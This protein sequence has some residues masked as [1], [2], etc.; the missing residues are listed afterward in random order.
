MVDQEQYR[1]AW[2]E[3]ANPGK[4]LAELIRRPKVIIRQLDVACDIAAAPPGS[5]QE[6]F[7][8]LS[9][10]EAEKVLKQAER[11][12]YLSGLIQSAKSG[13]EEALNEL[14][15]IAFGALPDSD[16]AQITRGAINEIDNNSNTAS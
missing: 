1:G 10:A 16:V 9:P 8:T 7:P 2:W 14:D 11:K 13:N 12:A 4:F 3:K 5:T 15:S 6:D